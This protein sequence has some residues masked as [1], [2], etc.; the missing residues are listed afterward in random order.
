MGK[1]MF[2]SN[3]H[4][5]ISSNS[6]F[7]KFRNFFQISG[8]FQNVL[9]FFEY[10]ATPSF[11]CLALCLATIVL[12]RVY[13]KEI[14]SIKN[15]LDKFDYKLKLQGL[16]PIE[17]N[18]QKRMIE[19]AAVCLTPAAVAKLCVACVTGA[20]ALHASISTFTGVD[21]SREIGAIFRD[22]QEFKD[23]VKH[24]VNKEEYIKLKERY[25]G[26]SNKPHHTIDAVIKAYNYDITDFHNGRVI[27]TPIY[28]YP[29]EDITK[30]PRVEK[31]KYVQFSDIDPRYLD[32]KSKGS[33]FKVLSNEE[34]QKLKSDPSKLP[35]PGV[36]WLNI[37]ENFD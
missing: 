16:S 35:A 6:L 9:K 24:V 12:Y 11:L 29:D 19:T 13:L 10:S 32:S 21:A 18:Y 37:R 25:P 23:I 7:N 34:Y 5:F 2:C 27:D 15:S 31:I 22:E 1:I 28:G 26:L 33:L 30:L 36:A 20:A 14:K 4:S 8:N 17:F 3:T